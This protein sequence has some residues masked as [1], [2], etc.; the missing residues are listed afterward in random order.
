MKITLIRKSKGIT[1]AA[2]AERS[3]MTQQQIARLE[4]GSVDPRLGTLR[5]IADA[6][7]CDLPELFFTRAEFLR[8]VQEVADSHK[9]TLPKLP[10]MDLNGLCA[11]ERHIPTFHPLWEEVVFKNG[12]VTL[13]GGLQHG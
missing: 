12:K 5:R 7:G 3:G 4:N 6:L 13:T 11:R 2:L 1:Q 8:T 9:L 10:I